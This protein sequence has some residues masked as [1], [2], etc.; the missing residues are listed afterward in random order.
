MILDCTAVI[1][2]PDRLPKNVC[3]LKLAYDAAVIQGIEL[4][5]TI[6]LSNYTFEI[7]NN[8]INRRNFNLNKGIL[9]CQ[10]RMKKF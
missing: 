5:N 7:I 9:K 8:N 2:L 3:A 1:I 6:R 10:D 4:S